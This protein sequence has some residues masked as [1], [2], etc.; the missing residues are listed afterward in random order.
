MYGGSSQR[1]ELIAKKVHELNEFLLNHPRLRSL[2]LPIRD[3]FTI[4]QYIPPNSKDP[5]SP[6]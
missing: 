3:G 2:L 1:Y 6:Q 4:L 5:S